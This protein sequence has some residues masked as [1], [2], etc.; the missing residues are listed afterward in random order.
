MRLRGYPVQS[1]TFDRLTDAKKWAQD[2]ESDIRD[3][4]HFKYAEAKKHMRRMRFCEE[5]GSGL[6][7]VVASIEVYQLPPLKI[8]AEASSTQVILY[9]PRAFSEMSR[10]ERKRVLLIDADPQCNATQAILSDEECDQIYLGKN[11]LAKMLHVNEKSLES[12]CGITD[13]NDKPA[14]NMRFY[15][16]EWSPRKQRISL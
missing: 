15:V 10:P 12:C 8:Q 16:I 7:K 2:T 3:R 9:G 4:R 13:G 5:Q 1:A 11:N 6:D 14:G